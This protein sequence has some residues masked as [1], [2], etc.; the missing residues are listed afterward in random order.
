MNRDSSW[1]G[2]AIAASAATIGGLVDAADTIG[3]IGDA[4]VEVLHGGGKILTA[5]NGGS[6]AEA[7]HMSEEF[8]GRFR[9]NRRALAA[10]ALVADPTAL[11]CIGNDFGFDYIFSRQV[12]GLGRAGDALVV[13]STSGNAPNLARALEAAREAEMVTVALLGR[14]GGPLAGLADHEIIVPGEATE[15]IQEA[16]QVI[17]HLL[18]DAAERVFGANHA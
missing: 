18:L 7:L 3:V 9:D 4:L 1:I 15:R 17:L 2:D 16:H 13:F 10:V 11:T 14:D 6:A 5:G 12:E 8:V